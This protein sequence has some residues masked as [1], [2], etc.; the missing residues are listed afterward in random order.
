[1]QPH[2]IRFAEGFVVDFCERIIFGNG[3]FEI[4]SED[5]PIHC[6]FDEFTFAGIASVNIQIAVIIYGCIGF[7]VQN[8][9]DGNLCRVVYLSIEMLTFGIISG[10]G[11]Y[12]SEAR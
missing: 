10:S 5:I 12:K 2:I 1:M 6:H 4:M 7:F 3:I 8:L 9:N 11:D